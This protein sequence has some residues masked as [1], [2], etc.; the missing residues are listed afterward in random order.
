MR[1]AD[2]ILTAAAD[3]DRLRGLI[4]HLGEGHAV[5]VRLDDGSEVRGIVS[6]RPTLQQFFDAAG[7]EG[8]NAWLRLDE[9]AMDQPESAGWCDIWLDRVNAV[10]E[11]DPAEH[12]RLRNASHVPSPRLD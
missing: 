1:T 10:R 8:T 4:E 7:N 9:P 5:A 2:R 11:L 6:E 12:V 3:I